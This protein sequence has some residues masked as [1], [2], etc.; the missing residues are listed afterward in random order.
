MN[1]GL[2]LEVRGVSK[3]YRTGQSEVVALR[4]VSLTLGR[5]A[6]IAI[7]GP[8]GSG[9]TT[10]L[11]VIAGLDRPTAGEVWIAGRRLSDLDAEAATAFRRRHVGFVF[12]F[13][14]LLPTMSARENVA[15]PLLAERLPRREIDVRTR[16][17]L[18]AMGLHHRAN[19]RPSELSGGEQ[20][21][22]AI[23]RALVMRPKL[24]LA[25]EPTGNLD[26][27]AGEDVL[28]VLR[29]AMGAFDLS[30]VMVTH[31]HI[32]AV[33]MD[34]VMSMHDGSLRTEIAPAVVPSTLRAPRLR[35]VP[36]GRS[37]GDE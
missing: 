27:V 29:E 16:E 17:M 12:Q 20:Q 37:G 7:M 36:P 18:E 10:L 11:N 32:A 22:V 4:D 1:E 24:L 34:T 3:A 5:Q 19:H 25:D 33:T 8:S 31:S 28:G 26:S 30:I 15:V 23:A 35:V 13:F 2:L 21:R 9:K 6:S 14:N